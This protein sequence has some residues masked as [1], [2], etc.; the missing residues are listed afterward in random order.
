MDVKNVPHDTWGK[1]DISCLKCI[2]TKYKP[3]FDI[4]IK[5]CFTGKIVSLPLHSDSTT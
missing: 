5:K 2:D 3:K 4:C 1:T